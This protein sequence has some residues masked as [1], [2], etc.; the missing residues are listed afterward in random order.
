MSRAA[1]RKH[2][3][4][5]NVMTTEQLAEKAIRDVEQ[6]SPD[7]KA[8]LRALLDRAWGPSNAAK[9]LR[10]FA[11][12]ARRCAAEEAALANYD[13]NGKPVN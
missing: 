7:E 1:K 11:D 9:K 2:Q 5:D 12:A 10:G 4:T 8:E 6:M 3:P 13:G